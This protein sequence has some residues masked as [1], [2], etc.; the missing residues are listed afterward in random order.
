MSYSISPRGGGVRDFTQNFTNI[1][2]LCD[3]LSNVQQEHGDKPMFELKD[4]YK[5][6]D[7]MKKVTNKPK[8]QKNCR[9][10]WERLLDYHY[11]SDDDDD[12]DI[13]VCE[14]CSELGSRQKY[15]PA[16]CDACNVCQMCN[17]YNNGDC[18][19]C[20][21]SCH[22]DGQFYRDKIPESEIISERDIELFNKATQHTTS[23][24]L[25]RNRF[26]VL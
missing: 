15:D 21:Y 8:C 7:E 19:G 17:E 11:D 5:I 16:I 25:K 24:R 9:F 14:S 20:S 22:R 23:E 12:D 1:D 4:E 3:V 10:K 26:S 2:N 18:D 13:Y 6:L